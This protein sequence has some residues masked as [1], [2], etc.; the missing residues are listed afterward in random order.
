MTAAS[1]AGMPR[2]FGPHHALFGI[3]HAAATPRGALLLC[4]PLGQEMIRSQRTYRLLAQA[5]AERGHAVLR[6]DYR[7]TGDS[8]D[9]GGTPSWASCCADIGTA[10]QELRNACGLDTVSAF[11]ARLGANLAMAAVDSAR[12]DSVMALDPV[13]DG[14]QFVAD[15]DA[16]QSRLLLDG[17]RF[18]Q[19]RRDME[20][21]AEW[22][23]FSPGLLRDELSRI[24]WQLGA[25][26]R[27][28]IDS[29]PPARTDATP[30]CSTVSV[31]QPI[32][33]MNLDAQEDV[34]IAHDIVQAVI[35]HVASRAA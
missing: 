7:G 33:W 3:Y 14:A 34:I 22:V 11:G 23:G 9:A 13:C 12:L 25:A 4:P 2:Y 30:A 28:Q 8:A 29:T 1:V 16:L 26:L 17:N 24:R 32:P 20:P 21:H 27:F 35:A 15:M 31:A 18:L 6:F 10:A 19:P 5:L